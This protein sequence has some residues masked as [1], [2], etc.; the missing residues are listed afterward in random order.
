MCETKDDLTFILVP[1]AN[2]SKVK[3]SSVVIVLAREDD[4][5]QVSRMS[6]CD[7]MG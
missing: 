1:V 4:V 7:R 2:V 3:D 6:I 5:L